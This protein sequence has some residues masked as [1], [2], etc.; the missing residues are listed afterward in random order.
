[1][2]WIDVFES[3]RTITQRLPG[4]TI[5]GLIRILESLCITFTFYYFVAF[6]NVKVS[7]ILRV[8]V[9]IALVISVI[10]FFDIFFSSI[11]KSLIL[12][13]ANFTA[14]RITGL[15]GEPRSFARSM[16]LAFLIS[17]TSLVAKSQVLPKWLLLLCSIQSL[18]CIILS[19]SASALVAIAM[20]VLFLHLF[21]GKV[22]FKNLFRLLGMLSLV[23]LGILG[24]RE[25]RNHL[26]SRLIEDSIHGNQKEIKGVPTL[27]SKLEV[28][29]AAAAGFFFHNPRFL[30]LGTGPNTINIPSSVYLSRYSKGI[31]RH[32][33]NSIPHTGFLQIL[34]R[35]GALGLI[36]HFRFILVYYKRADKRDKNNIKVIMANLIFA[37]FVLSSQYYVFLGLLAANYYEKRAQC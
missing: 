1:M 33:I 35:S 32:G 6:K 25:Y 34:S 3:F 7:Y 11:I 21:F 19:M 23:V 2:P 27:I 30:L 10:T 31:Y 29:D 26:A 12:G 20:S 8:F 22:K 28:F 14:N 37:L 36:L 13:K 5:V 9:L 17:Y 4:R 15:S 18:V 24:N 16:S